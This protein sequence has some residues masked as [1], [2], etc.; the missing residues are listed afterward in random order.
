MDDQK[1]IDLYWERSPSAITE[2]DK[3][4]GKY[5]FAIANRILL[6]HQYSEECVND[7]YLQA[8]NVIP[9]QRPNRFST[10]LG[11]ITRNLALNRYAHEKAEK[12]GSGAV[13][14]SL[15]ELEECLCAAQTEDLVDRLALQN[16]LNSF[17]TE[18]RSA[19]RQI[20][21]Q[22]Y[23]YFLEIRQIAREMLMTEGQVKM[24]LH[25]MRGELKCRLEKEGLL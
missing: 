7:T 1:I 18:L 2:T 4:Y 23:W 11:T 5:C 10:F 19:D 22:R 16:V 9:P 15:D 20:F 6:D 8:W 12:R 17:L 14:A 3:K 13:A 21:L 25:R 24:R